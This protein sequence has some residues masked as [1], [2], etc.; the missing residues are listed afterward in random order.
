MLLGLLAR[1]ADGG[2][3]LAE[4]IPQEQMRDDLLAAAEQALAEA[5]P[6]V[7]AEMLAAAQWA[8]PV[9]RLLIARTVTDDP[10]A[11]VRL[12]EAELIGLS[13]QA[14][15]DAR[16]ASLAAD[17]DPLVAQVAEALA[18]RLASPPETQPDETPATTAP[19]DE[20]DDA[21][22][23]PVPEPDAPDEPAQPDADD[24]D[25]LDEPPTPAEAQK[26][27]E[28]ISDGEADDDTLVL[29]AAEDEES[30]ASQ[31]ADDA[32]TDGS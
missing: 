32:D 6:V 3:Q 30:P 4:G 14:P 26:D 12:R 19:A 27:A 31:P 18:L 2:A 10:S 20:P 7:R 22:A 17:A 1:V 29:D 25:D 28:A 15:D 23:P 11:L 8:A 9:D 16:L 5:S 24:E 13:T 21:V